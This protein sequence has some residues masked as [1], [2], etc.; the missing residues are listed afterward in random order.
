MAPADLNRGALA[1]V[2]DEAELTDLVVTGTIPE[3]LTGTLLRNGP[4]P[5]GGRFAGSDVLDWWPEAAMPASI[6][7]G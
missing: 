3:E 6:V 7:A 2:A 4:N 5:F 1:P